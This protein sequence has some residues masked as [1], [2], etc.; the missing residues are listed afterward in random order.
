MLAIEFMELNKSNIKDTYK[1]YI[2]YPMTWYFLISGFGI[3]LLSFLLI[4]F[5][6][7]NILY[8]WMVGISIAI[9]FS[10]V[11]RIFNGRLRKTRAGFKGNGLTQLFIKIVFFG[12]IFAAIIGTN[13]NDEGSWT[14]FND[15]VSGLMLIINY[16]MYNF[17][18]ILNLHNVLTEV[19]SK[20]IL[21][22]E[23]EKK[24]AEKLKRAEA[25]VK[26]IAKKEEADKLLAKSS[27]KK[28]EG[29]KEAKKMPKKSSEKLTTK[30]KPKTPPKTPTN[31]QQK[32]SI[33]PE[34]KPKPK[35]K[36]QSKK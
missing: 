10:G 18:F 19:N 1:K 4:W 12:L 34:L 25:K 27:T 24:A 2:K 21:V 30:S 11:S 9:L 22:K 7:E 29:N 3:I 14:R 28:L 17:L 35:E 15:P 33:K 32:P 36:N 16:T 8:G 13:T 5:D 23:Q 6:I 31:L 20:E 26:R